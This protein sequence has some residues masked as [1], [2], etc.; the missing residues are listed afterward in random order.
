MYHTLQGIVISTIRHKDHTFVCRIFTGN[1]GLKTFVIRSGK[2]VK[3]SKT[4]LLQPMMTVEFETAL[5]ESSQ[6]NT[7]KDLRVALVL[8]EVFFHPVKSSMLLFLNELL[9][10]TIPDDYI[11]Q[12]LFKF[13]WN[14]I[15]LLDDAIDARNF[16][17]WCL[18]EI[19]RHY[20]FYPYFENEQASFFDMSSAAFTLN[21]PPHQYYLDG[22]NCA[23]LI[24][25]TDKDWLQVQPIQLHSSVRIKLLET[26]VTFL[27]LH[28]E[29][30]REIK[31]L[32]IL[33]E[34]FH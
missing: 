10:K 4:N 23:A 20:G 28:L 16:H 8:S 3:T 17:L 5:K 22:E 34:L 25:I 6:M 1:Y 21:R 29:N 30:L 12:R 14:S 19:S 32:A 11:N 27:K 31:S 33:H 26:L 15:Q 13:L 2:S 7:L 9:S 24:A 18:L